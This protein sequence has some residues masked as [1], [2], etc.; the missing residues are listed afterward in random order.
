MKKITTLIVAVM[1]TAILIGCGKQEVE[2]DVNK[3]NESSAAN[4]DTVNTETAKFI[5]D[6]TDIDGNRV[7]MDDFADAKLIMINFWEPWCG[8]CVR[9]MPDLEKL[10]EEYSDEGFM[11]L[12]I[13][14]TADME[15]EVG[16]VLESC[17]TTYPILNYDDSMK[18]FITDYV[19]TTIFIDGQGNV[20]TNEPIV[21]GQSYDDWKQI[22]DK[23]GMSSAGGDQSS[24][25]NELGEG[26]MQFAFE[27]VDGDGNVTNFI[28]NTDKKTVGEALV[29]IGLISGEDSEFGLYVKTV[30]GITADYDVDKTYWA[31]YVDGEY[32]SAGVDQTDVTDGSTYSFKVEK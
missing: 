9:E 16:E 27:V 19:P 17:G 23:M 20:L 22:I 15:K 32:A 5:L 3:S 25:E 28:I 1:L 11:I 13:Y 8:P 31:F 18:G 2:T 7:T 12:G 29:D 24:K 14:S 26:K 21:G 4:I 10:Y 30:N 6:T